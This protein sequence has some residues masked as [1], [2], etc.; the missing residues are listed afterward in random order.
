[1]AASTELMQLYSISSNSSAGG[2]GRS[3][4]AADS[5]FELITADWRQHDYWHALLILQQDTDD[6]AD[7]DG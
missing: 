5:V 6:D 3:T 4:W 2:G 7:D 1:M